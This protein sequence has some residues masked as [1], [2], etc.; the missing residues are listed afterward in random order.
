MPGHQNNNGGFITN[1]MPSANNLF[2]N[3]GGP[4]NQNF[5]EHKRQDGA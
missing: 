2:N 1:H 5:E 3:N 4:I